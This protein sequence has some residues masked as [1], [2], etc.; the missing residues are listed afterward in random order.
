M[1]IMIA[2]QAGLER[3]EEQTRAMPDARRKLA[4]LVFKPFNRIGAHHRRRYQPLRSSGF[5][6]AGC[7]K[8]ASRMSR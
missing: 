2:D 8:N 6:S 7:I 3:F 4:Q 5:D 1:Q